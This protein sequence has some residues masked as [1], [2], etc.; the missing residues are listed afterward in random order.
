MNWTA[1][2]AG[3]RRIP[4]DRVLATRILAELESMGIP[5]RLHFSEDSGAA[6]GSSIVPYLLIF[7]PQH[8]SAVEQ[9]LADL[10]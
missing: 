4:P 6:V 2:A 3:S 5:C 1:G 7:P 10:A 9:L 8:S